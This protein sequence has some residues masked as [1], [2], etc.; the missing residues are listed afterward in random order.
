MQAGG[1]R[2]TAVSSK[3]DPCCCTGD[4]F[5]S[6]LFCMFGWVIW[7]TESVTT[8]F[9]FGLGFGLV[10]L[11][12]LHCGIDDDLLFVF[13]P[14]LLTHAGSI[15]LHQRRFSVVFYT[16]LFSLV[17]LVSFSPG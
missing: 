5:L 12:D 16:V 10:C 11:W 13:T 3:I 4:D 8:L 2:P 14:V 1:F 6:F 9:R 7:T 15:L 17:C